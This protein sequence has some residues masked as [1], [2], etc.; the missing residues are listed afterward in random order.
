MSLDTSNLPEYLKILLGEIK[1]I[2]ERID[3][4]KIGDKSKVEIVTN[5]KESYLVIEVESKDERI[6][7]LQLYGEQRGQG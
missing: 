7:G 4:D 3:P 2:L 6:P 5:K 1:P